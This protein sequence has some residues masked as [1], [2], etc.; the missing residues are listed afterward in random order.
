MVRALLETQQL[1]LRKARSPGIG[2]LAQRAEGALEC[3]SSS[4]RLLTFP[5]LGVREP[6]R[7]LFYTLR[8]RTPSKGGSCCYRTPRRRAGSLLTHID[9]I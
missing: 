6:S 9:I 7:F 2:G 3:G 8:R 1:S 4:Y 5:T